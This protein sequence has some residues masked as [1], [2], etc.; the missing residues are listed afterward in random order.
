MRILEAH[1]P[2]S[3]ALYFRLSK[4]LGGAE[5]VLKTVCILYRTVPKLEHRVAE[6]LPHR[7]SIRI[8]DRDSRKLTQLPSFSRALRTEVPS[9]YT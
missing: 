9:K 6:D 8:F 5:Q 1:D 4:P 7:R 3:R 2:K